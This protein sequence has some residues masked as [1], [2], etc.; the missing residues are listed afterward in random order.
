MPESSGAAL[1]ENNG[2]KILW[3]SRLKELAHQDVYKK[4]KGRDFVITAIRNLALKRV[5]EGIKEG[6]VGTAK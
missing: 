2:S 1:K 5:E 4:R 3:V 6:G